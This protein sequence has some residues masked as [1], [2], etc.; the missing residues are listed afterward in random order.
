MILYNEETTIILL[1]ITLFAQGM[2]MLLSPL[3]ALAG[4]YVQY[5]QNQW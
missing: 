4:K 1:P 3:W 2:Q 5:I